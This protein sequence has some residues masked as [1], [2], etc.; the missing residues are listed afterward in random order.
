MEIQFDDLLKFN[1]YRFEAHYKG[2]NNN[3]HDVI[4]IIEVKTDRSSEYDYVDLLFDNIRIW[5]GNGSKT[6]LATMG[7]TNFRLLEPGE[8]ESKEWKE[9][10]ECGGKGHFDF[11]E[12]EDYYCKLCYGTG[13]VSGTI[14][15]EEVFKPMPVRERTDLDLLELVCQLHSRSLNQPHNKGMHDAYVEARKEME[16]R[17]RAKETLTKRETISTQILAGMLASGQID[18]VDLPDNEEAQYVADAIRFTDLL[19]KKLGE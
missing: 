6:L 17:L 7:I 12:P 19:L 8:P 13:V 1:G 14:K 11:R 15:K 16:S 18:L 10:P 5:V 9:C 2:L 4:G 3:S